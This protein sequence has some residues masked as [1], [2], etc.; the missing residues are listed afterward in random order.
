MPDT[1]EVAIS[2]LDIN[3]RG[4][5]LTRYQEGRIAVKAKCPDGIESWLMVSVPVPT[6][7]MCWMGIVWGWPK[8]VADIM[9]VTPTGAEVIYEGDV[10]LSMDFTPGPVDNEAELR[11]R[12][13]FEG[14]SVINFRLHKGGACLVRGGE[15]EG[16]RVVDWQA[17]KV[18][19]CV[20]P[21]DP[22]SGLIAPDSVTPGV[23][24]RTINTGGGDIVSEKV[25]G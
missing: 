7:L 13:K 15:R 14:E 18:K 25:K 5:E 19:V 24:Q 4:D 11:A 21:E 1:P 6:L 8:Y 2:M 10:R 3:M 16:V 17:G 9:T 23:Y 22:W 12:G 20:R